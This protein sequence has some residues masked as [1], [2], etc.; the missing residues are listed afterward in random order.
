MILWVL[1]I[2]YGSFYFCRSNL[3]A[4]VGDLGGE[5]QLTNTQIGTILGSLK[6]AY[7]IGQLVNGQLAERFRPRILLAIGMMCSAA[8]NVVFGFGT[9]FYFLLFVWAMNGYAQSLGWTPCMRV[10]ANWFPAGRRGRAIGI[11]G[12]G[13]QFT[14]AVTI[15]I[16]GWAV[17][18]F[19]W[20]GALYLPSAM[21]FLSGLHMLAFLK[22]RPESTSNMEDRS[23]RTPFVRTLIST[24]SN[25]AL[26]F[27]GL[28]LGLLNACRYGFLD[29]GILLFEEEMGDR[30]D[31]AAVKITLLP[32]GGIV[33]ALV[34]GWA[35]DRFFG[36]RRAPVI[37]GLLVLLGG[38]TLCY[39][40]VVQW[41]RCLAGKG[42]EAIG[43][44]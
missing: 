25:P 27:L 5:L 32:I 8:L 31:V 11:I 39:H 12:T 41:A 13:Y 1:W 29:W 33:G 30:V 35:T 38:L 6:I 43:P 17:A 3:S 36:G 23:E 16:S 44:G 40:Q 14:A 15:L 34:T 21:L 19:G 26:W 10:A 28:S 18:K 7:G 4:A 37:V 24:I 20:Q 42:P 22:E 2:T 9:G